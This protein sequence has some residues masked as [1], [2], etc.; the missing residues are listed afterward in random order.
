MTKTVRYLHYNFVHFV[1]L[2]IPIKFDIFRQKLIQV[3][4]KT[5][6]FL[7]YRLIIVK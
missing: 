6:A 4:K 2:N 5:D 3:S 7:Y 1:Q